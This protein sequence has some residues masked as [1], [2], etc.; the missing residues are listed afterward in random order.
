MQFF[1]QAALGHK[2][3]TSRAETMLSCQP[4]QTRVG[5]HRVAAFM[6]YSRAQNQHSQWAHTHTHTHTRTNSLP[7]QLCIRYACMLSI[8][9]T[10][11]MHARKHGCTHAFSS[12][13]SRCFPSDLS[14]TGVEMTSQVCPTSDWAALGCFGSFK[15]AAGTRFTSGLDKS[16]SQHLRKPRTENVRLHQRHV[17]LCRYEYATLT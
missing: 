3:S 16:V 12:G 7:Y 1:C 14:F 9:N 11:G 4:D 10:A 2:D 15:P 13:P 8:Q 17:F 6:T 5:K